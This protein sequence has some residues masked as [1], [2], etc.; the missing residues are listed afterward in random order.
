[1]K[2]SKI[3]G[4]D[5]GSY[6]STVSVYEGTEIKIIPNS[7][8]GLS[9]PSYVAFTKDGSIKIGEPAK[10]QAT[11]NPE[12]TIFN[13]K[14]LMGKTYE[15]VKHLKRPYK[16]VDSNGRAAVQ[17]DDKVYTPEEISAMVI[18]K[19][20]K[21]AEDF[22]G[23]EVTRAIITVPAHFNS[24]E[25]QATKL[26]GEIAGLT[27][28]RIIAEPT[29]AVL[30]VDSKSEKKYAVYD[31]GGVTMDLSIVDVAD[32]VFEILATDGD[33]DL[34]GSLIDE[35]IVNW[36]AEEFI[37]TEGMD[38]RKDPMAHQRLFEAAEKAKIELSS[39]SSTDINLPYITAIDGV[40]K[41]LVT[42]LTKSN[43]E[44]LVDDIIER[45]ID[46][47]KSALKSSKLKISDIDEVLL[48]GGSSRIPLVQEK[49]EKLFN[50]KPSKSLNPDTCVSSGATVQGGVL[51]GVNSDILLLDVIPL[52]LGIETMGGVST[53]LIEANTT[54]PTKKSNTFSTAADNQPSVEIHVL[55]GERPMAKDN[56]SLGRFHL[57]GIEPQPRGVP[58]IFVEFNV[59]SNGIISVTAKDEASGKE[60]HIRIEND[61]QLSKEE[62]E[63]MKKEAEANA[64]NDKK[65]REK[66][67]KINAADSMIFQTE[68][69]IKEFDEKLTEED[70][71][72]LKEDLEVLKT[73]HSEKDVDKIDKAI[74]KLNETWQP[75]ATRMYQETPP[76]ETNTQN[77]DNSDNVEDVSYTEE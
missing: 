20:K 26:A 32:G 60:N 10:R 8:G 22:L 73:A 47:A 63:R 17:I 45:T 54:I 62:I 2:N 77:T 9:T 23:E 15:Q 41:H 58:K 53:V 70:K 25:R 64:E 57:D 39:S 66:I 19:M 68:K 24:E 55:Q 75:I 16:I 14:R 44:K 48:V 30:N 18:Q 46:K 69:Q 40:P 31:F 59:D 42:N 56:K 3:V 33:I 76:P 37:K 65:E 67:D 28:E 52:S 5:L 29:A 11:V 7:E 6:N 50:K 12:K 35:R 27:V 61:T 38:L 1:M 36:I 13:I 4:I 43:F 49:L 71:T 74:N 34:G 72:K 51:S 21:T